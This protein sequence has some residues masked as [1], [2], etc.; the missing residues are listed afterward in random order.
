MVGTS[1]TVSPALRQ[2]A[3]L[4]RKSRTVLTMSMARVMAV[5]GGPRP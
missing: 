2:A 5:S 4:V 3:T 1:A